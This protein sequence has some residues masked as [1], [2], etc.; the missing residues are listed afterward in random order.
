MPEKIL[1]LNASEMPDDRVFSVLD[2]INQIRPITPIVFPNAAEF[3]RQYIEKNF[4]QER[5]QLEKRKFAEACLGQEEVT[6]HQ[7]SGKLVIVSQDMYY[8]GL[9]TDTAWVFG[10]TKPLTYTLGHSVLSTARLKDDI[11][12]RD[13]LRHELGHL[14]RAPSKGRANTYEEFGPHCSNDLCVM[15][16]NLSVKSSSKYAHKR[17]RKNVDTYCPECQTDMKS[18]TV[19]Y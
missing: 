13:M 10:A 5:Q 18:F 16:Q 14:F 9:F 2:E 4:N 11:H 15:K 19:E 12:A 17:A 1:I 6:K 8:Q 3:L 7:A